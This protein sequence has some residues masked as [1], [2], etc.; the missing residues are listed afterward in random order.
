MCNH[1]RP[2]G[3]LLPSPRHE[4]RRTEPHR[5]EQVLHRLGDPILGDE[6]LH[7]QVDR[8]RHDARAILGGRTHPFGEIGGSPPAARRT[9]V[10]R[11]PVLRHFQARF[12]QIENLPL[13]YVP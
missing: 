6:L 4:A 5:A 3:G 11:G 2:F 9:A 7:V 1:A 13:R 12:R 10:D 8:R